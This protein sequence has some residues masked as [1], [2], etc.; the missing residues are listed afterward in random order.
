MK[1]SI[2]HDYRI[3]PG[4]L[5]TLIEDF[6]DPV[7]IDVRDP[8]DHARAHIPGAINLPTAARATTH[9]ALAERTHLVVVYA[10][11][12][13]DAQAACA[14]LR[15]AGLDQVWWLEGGL[16]R[17]REAGMAVVGD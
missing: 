6:T 13:P 2:P 15:A 16:A 11:T 10:D 12:D 7:F 9:P 1:G 17:W 14:Q 3:A 8:A 4:E 5:D